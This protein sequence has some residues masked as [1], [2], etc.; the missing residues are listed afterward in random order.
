MNV[1][2]FTNGAVPPTRVDNSPTGDEGG[3]GCVNDQDLLTIF[4][5]YLCRT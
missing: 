3:V 4:P 5:P 2:A 1:S